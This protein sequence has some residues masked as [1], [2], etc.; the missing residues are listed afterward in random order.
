MSGS[1]PAAPEGQLSEICQQRSVNSATA[2][3]HRTCRVSPEVNLQGGVAVRPPPRITVTASAY[4]CFVSGRDGTV[5]VLVHL[6]PEAPAHVLGLWFPGDAGGSPRSYYPDLPAA[7]AAAAETVLDMAARL[8]WSLVVD[9][10]VDRLLYAAWWESFDAVDKA[11]DE[12]LYAEATAAYK[13]SAEAIH[14]RPSRP[15]LEPSPAACS[16]TW[17]PPSRPH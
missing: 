11:S 10:L 14:G 7:G 6:D 9:R 16:R 8:P 2:A 4:G 3:P 15:T 13:A 5:R 12:D 17:T 1:Q